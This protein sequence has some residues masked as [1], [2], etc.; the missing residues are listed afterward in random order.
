[1]FS[2]VNATHSSL[3]ILPLSKDFAIPYVPILLVQLLP[4]ATHN[5][6]Q[7]WDIGALKGI[8]S[9]VHLSSP[10]LDGL[11]QEDLGYKD[12]HMVK[13]Q[14]QILDRFAT[15]SSRDEFVL[16]DQYVPLSAD[17]AVKECISVRCRNEPCLHW[18]RNCSS[19]V[20]C[21]QL[22]FKKKKRFQYFQHFVELSS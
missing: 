12:R 5:Y 3:S 7:H 9:A 15:R 20:G 6:L 21:I 14:K 4:G 17:N 2:C 16:T 11:G 18:F 22:D 1:M 13:L 10:S 19:L 8:W